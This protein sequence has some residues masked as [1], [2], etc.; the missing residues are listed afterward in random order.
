MS[1]N[2]LKNYVLA[3][4]D[5]DPDLGEQARLVVLAALEAPEDLSEVLGGGAISPTRR[6]VAH[7]QRGRRTRQRR[8]PRMSAHRAKM[9]M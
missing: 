7:A 5:E 8:T 6:R 2:R 9:G 1:D 4:V 3:R